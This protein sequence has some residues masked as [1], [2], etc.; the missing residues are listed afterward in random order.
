LVFYETDSIVQV[1]LFGRSEPDLLFR[2]V[3]VEPGHSDLGRHDA[4]LDYYYFLKKKFDV[5]ALIPYR[6]SSKKICLYGTDNQTKMLTLRTHGPDH[7][8]LH[9]AK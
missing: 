8:R 1:S 6:I 4:D 7:R 5:V 2:E 9:R 3:D